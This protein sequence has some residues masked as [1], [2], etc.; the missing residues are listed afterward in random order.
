MNNMVDTHNAAAADVTA[1]AQ[2][3]FDAA[4]KNYNSAK[5][6]KETAD[7]ASASYQP[8]LQGAIA[9]ESKTRQA[10]D[11]ANKS[12]DDLLAAARRAHTAYVSTVSKA[13]DSGNF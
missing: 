4:V 9:D 11:K 3:A 5:A 7:N 1:K 13:V 6:A 12:R 8:T 2:K 10:S